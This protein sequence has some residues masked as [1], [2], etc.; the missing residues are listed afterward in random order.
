[1]INYYSIDNKEL[2]EYREGLKLLWIDMEEPSIEEIEQIV[3]K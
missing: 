1:M 2:V 3:S